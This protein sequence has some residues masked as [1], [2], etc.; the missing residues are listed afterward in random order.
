M[1]TL[2]CRKFCVETLGFDRR[3]SLLP[4]TSPVRF[5]L[6]RS[7]DTICVGSILL[8]HEPNKLGK[9]AYGTVEGVGGLRWI[10]K[11]PLAFRIEQFAWQVV[12]LWP[13]AARRRLWLPD[14]V[15]A[16]QNPEHYLAMFCIVR[17]EDPYIE[18]WLE[19]HLMM[20]VTHFFIYDNGSTD[21]TRDILSRYQTE[22]V[23]TIVPWDNFILGW[24]GV[25]GA[26][27]RMQR[28]AI[29]AL[30]GQLWTPGR[31]DCIHRS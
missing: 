24:E 1:T 4:P 8:W 5:S 29:V 31:M 6:L 27:G 26:T 14:P 22:G 11:S 9:T 15:E 10:N 3:S 28:L 12:G 21:R 2:D 25:A 20:G 16:R 30:S 19:F 17:N 18:E 13:D 7:V 23:A